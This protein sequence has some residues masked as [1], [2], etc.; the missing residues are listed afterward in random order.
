MTDQNLNDRAAT[1]VMG[2]VRNKDGLLWMQ[3]KPHH[4][5]VMK[6]SD[7]DPLHNIAYADRLRVEIGKMSRE[8]QLRFEQALADMWQETDQQVPFTIWLTP[9]HITRAAVETCMKEKP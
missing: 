4:Y 8:V 2:W 1:L 7:F 3:T 5:P 9:E 6:V